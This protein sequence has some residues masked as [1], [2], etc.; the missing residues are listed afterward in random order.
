M[1]ETAQRWRHRAAHYGVTW[2][3]TRPALYYGIRRTIRRRD[4]LCVSQS[5]ELVIE[6]FPRSANST[7]AHG[8]MALQDRPVALAHHKHHVA[9]ILRAVRWHIP[10]IVLV[11]D[12]ADTI[13]S[14]LALAEEGRVR[15]G[16]T[17][18]GNALTFSDAAWAWL[19]FYRAVLPI[20]DKVVVA[21]FADVT[22]DLAGVIAEVNMRHGTA[23]R[24]GPLPRL[25]KSTTLGWHALPNEVRVSIKNDLRNRLKEETRRARLHDVLTR[26]NEV[27]RELTA[28]Q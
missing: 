24:T 23:F 2:L 20:R 1:S 16:Q 26:C 8:F 27:Y 21:R 9:Q 22:R 13:V 6:G 7:T 14:L 28:P 19:C 5:T 11:R 15:T 4:D 17:G 12:P 10:A 18:R 25:E 3:S